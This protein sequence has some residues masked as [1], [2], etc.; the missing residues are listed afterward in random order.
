MSKFPFYH[1]LDTIVET[2]N[3]RNA[4]P[5]RAYVSAYDSQNV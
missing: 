3:R 5:V 4:C 1:Q 2:S